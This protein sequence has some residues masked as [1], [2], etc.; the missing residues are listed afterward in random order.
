MVALAFHGIQR[1]EG[2]FSWFPS[3]EVPNLVPNLTRS[4]ECGQRIIVGRVDNTSNVTLDPLSL[5]D[6][7]NTTL[8][9]VNGSVEGDDSPLDSRISLG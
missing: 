5:V 7:V 3:E 2:T 1:S 4:L 6:T 8:T 9:P